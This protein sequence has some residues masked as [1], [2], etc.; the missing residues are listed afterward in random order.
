M[1]IV[2]FLQL[3][4]QVFD[5][6]R[7]DRDRAPTPARP[8]AALRDRSPARGRCT[9]AA[10]GR[11]KAASADSS[12]RSF[13]SSHS[14]AARQAA[15][16]TI[17]YS[18]PALS[19]SRPRAGRTPR[20]RRSTSETD[21]TSETPC[22]PGAAARRRRPSGRDVAC[23]RA[24]ISPFDARPVDHVVHAVEPAQERALAATRRTDER[25]HEIGL[26]PDGDVLQGPRRA[27][28]EVHPLRFDLAR[29]GVGHGRDEARDA[30]SRRDGTGMRFVCCSCFSETWPDVMTRV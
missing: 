9:A 27:V 14:A 15:L 26:N 7:R 10:A 21:S 17:S 30:T 16:S 2:Y 22:R 12:S 6:R 29:A 8:S 3:E 19:P 25:R 1:T 13:T 11:R 23:R 5:A 24:A 4:N 18:C 20:S 28:V